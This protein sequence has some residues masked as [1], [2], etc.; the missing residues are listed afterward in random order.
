MR[1]PWPAM[2]QRPSAEGPAVTESQRWRATALRVSAPNA[3]SALLTMARLGWVAARRAANSGCSW[4]A[5]LGFCS[6]PDTG[7]LGDGRLSGGTPGAV[8]GA[9]GLD[10]AGR[11]PAWRAAVA[12][13]D[14]VQLPAAPAASAAVAPMG[15]GAV[16]PATPVA[17][18][19]LVA[20]AVAALVA[21]VAPV[22]VVVAVPAGVVPWARRSIF[23]AMPRTGELPIT[24]IGAWPARG[25]RSCQ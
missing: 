2:R 14:G 8:S 23:P 1:A 22:A 11:P 20:I 3:D 12:G 19:A 9:A 7:L 24:R 15:A 18:A 5:A 4:E 21:P 25:W 13:L 16:L 10:D 6:L 17:P